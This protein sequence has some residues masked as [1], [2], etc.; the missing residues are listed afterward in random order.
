MKRENLLVVAVALIVCVLGLTVSVQAQ[1]ADFVLFGDPNPE[2]A[3]VAAERQAVHPITAPY[4]HEDSFNTTDVRLWYLYHNFPDGSAIGGGF[5]RGYA[6]QLRIALT[7]Q[8][9][10]VAY[11]DG[12]L[13]IESGLVDDEGWADIG[14]GVKWN[15]LQDFENDLHAAVGIGYQ[16]GSGDD[17]ALQDNDELRIWGSVNKGYDRLHLGATVNVLL[18]TGNEGTL[19]AS[20]RLTWHLHADYFL[21]EWFSPV[22]EL[23]GYHVLDEGDNAP[24]PFMGVDL[25]SLG[26][27]Q[28]EDVVT[29]GLGGEFRPLEDFRDLKIRA[30]YET[31]LTNNDE[32][33][34]WRWTVSAVLSF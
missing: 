1:H 12:Y 21:T 33:F 22:V 26:G 17:E 30:A 11:K 2:A 14:A 24:L 10:L 19:G 3:G 16:F 13:D 18:N 27:G 25:A 6:A 4:L 7:E 29:L 9:Q 23:N 5:A 34:G 20:D 31:P 28:S 32:L 8:L 15:F